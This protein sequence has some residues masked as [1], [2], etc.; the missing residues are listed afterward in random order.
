[1]PMCWPECQARYGKPYADQALA[2]FRWAVREE[3]ISSHVPVS[4]TCF[5][6]ERS[7]SN[8]RDIREASQASVF[9]QSPQMQVFYPDDFITI[10]SRSSLLEHILTQAGDAVMQTC[11]LSARLLPI[12]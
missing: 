11:H 5:A 9:Q 4:T 7:V 1:M 12:F 2:I 8:A 3:A 6:A 10:A